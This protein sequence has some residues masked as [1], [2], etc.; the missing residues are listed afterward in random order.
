MERYNPHAQSST[1]RCLPQF[2]PSIKATYGMARLHQ[3]DTPMKLSMNS[4]CQKRPA[5]SLPSRHLYYTTPQT[6]CENLRGL[7]FGVAPSR[8]YHYNTCPNP[9][10][11]SGGLCVVWAFAPSDNIIIS[12]TQKIWIFWGGGGGKNHRFSRLRTVGLWVVFLE[13]DCKIN[14]KL[15]IFYPKFNPKFAF[16]FPQ[17]NP[18]ANP[19][20]FPTFPQ[21]FSTPLSESLN[22]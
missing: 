18:T 4:L 13:T 22:P 20:P 15:G 9:I 2:P 11:F 5:R 7:P 8:H 10:D 14:A 21:Q 1:A 3:P 17:L 16:I 12:R 19:N 6:S